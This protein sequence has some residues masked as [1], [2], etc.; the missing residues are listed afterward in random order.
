MLGGSGSGS[1]Y[2]YVEYEEG[3]YVGYR[4]Y[5]TKAYDE[6]DFLVQIGRAHV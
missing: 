2:Y 5:E 4:Y 1:G 3:I 6:A